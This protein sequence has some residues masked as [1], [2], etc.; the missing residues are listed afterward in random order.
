ML[1]FCY[2]S[3]TGDQKNCFLYS[4]LYAEDNDIYKQCLLESWIAEYF[5]V[6]CHDVRAYGH[7]VLEHLENMSLLEEGAS[8]EYVRMHKCIRQMA[9]NILSD[10]GDRRYMV[11]ARE[12]PRNPEIEENWNEMEWI[13]LIDN[14]LQNLPDQ[15]GCSILSTL[16]LQKNTRLNKIPQSFFKDMQSLRVLDLYCTGIE[17]LPTSVS[18]LLNL[19]V[20]YLNDCKALMEL[21]SKIF[22]LEHLEIL[23]IRGSGIK[24]IPAHIHKFV[25]LK[26][27]RASFSNDIQEAALNCKVISMVSTLEELVIDVKTSKERCNEMLD[28][29]IEN[30]AT[31]NKLKIF[32]FRFINHEVVDV[33]KVVGT[34][35]HVFPKQPLFG[36][37]SDPAISCVISRADA[38]ELVNHNGAEHLWETGI[39]SMNRL[40]GCLIE[41]CK[42]KCPMLINIFANGLVRHLSV[43]QHLEIEGCFEIEEVIMK[44]DNAGLE[45]CALPKLQE[46]IFL[47]MPNLRSIWVD[48]SLEWPCLE[49]LEILRC[50]SLK[51]LPFSNANAPKLSYISTEQDWWEALQ[52][53]RHEVKEQFQQYCTFR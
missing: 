40:Q 7:G 43:L 27:L 48:E 11:K 32:Q 19:R 49:R 4:S 44:N 2:D 39:T 3:L 22:G 45:P 33:I 31:L 24:S 21:P 37:G 14:E 17:S 13:S 38:F 34:T 25:C 36:Q 5:R 10:M 41:S 26:H 51:R 1:K 46:V 18:N 6:R 47:D 28:Y 12:T 52:W 42:G 29:T 20:L 16:F 53:Q 30:V 35:P 15:P 8:T 50:P 23:D 9:L